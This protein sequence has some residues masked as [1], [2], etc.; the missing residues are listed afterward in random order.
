MHSS[1]TRQLGYLVLASVL[2][3]S[4]T[5]G[6]A[7]L[8]RA[9]TTG[10][11]TYSYVFDANLTGAEQVP[12]VSATT[13]TSTSGMGTTTA[14]TTGHSRVWFDMTSAS[15]TA[16]TTTMMWKTLH[17]WNGNDI[18][19]AHLH[20]GLP[21][22]TGPVV[23][24]LIHIAS[25]TDMNG[26][27]V[28][29]STAS[30]SDLHA[31]STGC[32]MPIMNLT[33]LA[34]AL[35]AGI[36]YTNVH[37]VE[38][39]NGVIRGQMALTSQSSTSTGS[40]NCVSTGSMN[41]WYDSN[42]TWHSCDS[43]GGMGGNSCNTMGTSTNNWSGWYDNAGVWHSCHGTGDNGGNSCN[44]MATSTNSHGWN[45]WYDR[46]GHWHS[47]TTGGNGGGNTCTV[48]NMN[49]WY[50]TNGTWHY[51]T[52]TG[53]GNGGGGTSTPNIPNFPGLGSGIN[54]FL[55][56]IFENVNRI[57]QTFLPTAIDTPSA[58][59]SVRTDR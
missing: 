29:T 32:S 1:T 48:S 20:C 11:T 55:S 10:T 14:T 47:C 53:G 58:L 21:G 27:L 56:K 24:D 16:T 8:A 6:F 2:A 17:V 46:S 51:C 57:F 44:N 26:V 40:S 12:P 37:S 49:G 19:A 23:L 3:L 22:Q 35:K 34:N 31:T 15:G 43:N 33:D 38:Y 7:T 4:L 5:V 54:G 30:Q 42:H 41:G 36:I 18:T 25:S 13:S 28:A 52:P 45:G 39:P 9:D 59:R 50:D